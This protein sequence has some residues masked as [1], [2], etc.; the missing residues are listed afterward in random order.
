MDKLTKNSVSLAGEFA[1]LSQ[2]ALR[3]FDANMTLGHTKGVDILISDRVSGRMCRMEVKTHINKFPIRAKT[4][5]WVMSEKSEELT[6]KNLFYCFVHIDTN[7]YN[8]KYYIL[9]SE[10]VAK[11]IKEG[12]MQWLK[13]KG[14]N[15]NTVRLFMLSLSESEGKNNISLAKNFENNWDLL[16]R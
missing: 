4:I 5:N 8:F 3:G 14:H 16:R 6:D 1:V 7:T 12:H 15:S 2:L 10:I 9:P 11:F 13:T